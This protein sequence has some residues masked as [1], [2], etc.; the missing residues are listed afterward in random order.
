MPTDISRRVMGLSAAKERFGPRADAIAR[1][2]DQGD[3][4]GDA[5]A[6]WVRREGYAGLDR[7]L[8]GERVDGPPEL[9]AFLVPYREIPRGWDRGRA[10]RGAAVQR[11]WTLH[12]G[13]ALRCLALPT[14]YLSPVGVQPLLHTGRMEHDLEQRLIRTGVFVNAVTSPGGMDPGGAGARACARVRIGH[15]MVRLSMRDAGWDPADGEVIPQPDMAATV[16]LFSSLWVTGVRRLGGR[17]S[18]RDADAVQHRW[19]RVGQM[20]GVDLDLLP[21]RHAEG[22]ELLALVMAL[23]G[24]PDP[25]AGKLTDVLLRGPGE[26]LPARLLGG[27]HSACATELLGDDGPRLSLRPTRQPWVPVVRAAAR[28]Q[29]AVTLLPGSEG[30]YDRFWTR[31]GERTLPAR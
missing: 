13:I 9:A 30:L 29:A 3:P 25:R 19:A 12:G 24:P 5:I 26:G 21:D 22:T 11:I 7:A 28:F 31:I 2:H 20:M 18:Q 14:S 27:L 17:I 16:Q 15:S 4:L 6:R 1:R 8:G 23:D 10:E